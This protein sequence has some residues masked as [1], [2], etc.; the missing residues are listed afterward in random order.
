V[1]YNATNL[2]IVLQYK[3]M[4]GGIV[5]LSYVLVNK[6]LV[7]TVWLSSNAKIL[8]QCI[9]TDIVGCFIWVTKRMHV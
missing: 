2:L 7:R 3:Y 1:S 5:Y 9:I 4:E 8:D 6:Q